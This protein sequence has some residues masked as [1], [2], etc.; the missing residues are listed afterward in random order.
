MIK[1][2]GIGDLHRLYA[3]AK[4]DGI[5]YN[6]IDTPTDFTVEAKSPFD[7]SYRRALHE[8]GFEMGRRGVPGKKAP[9]GLLR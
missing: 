7:N 1:T 6:L 3:I 8:T 5:D 9:P 4:R 2:Q